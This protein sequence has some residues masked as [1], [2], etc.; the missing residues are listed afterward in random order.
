MKTKNY[1][2]IALVLFFNNFYAQIG[3]GTTS[4]DAQL[5]IRSSNQ[6]TPAG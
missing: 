1:L 6:A 3:I 5:D 2:L 4:P